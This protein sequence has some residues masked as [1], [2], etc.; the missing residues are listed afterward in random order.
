M[1]AAPAAGLTNLAHLDF[2]SQQVT[3]ADTPAHSSYRLDQDPTV[4][5]L[6]VYAD[7]RSDGTF[8][9]VGGGPLDAVANTYAQGAYDADDIARAA[10]V[11]LRQWRATGDQKAKQQAYQQL[12]GLSYM[13]TLTGPT[14]GEVV[15]WMQPDGSLNP[16]PTPVELPDP[17]DSGASY[18][19]ARS[20]WAFGEGYAAFQ[21][22]DPQF[23]AFLKARMDLAVTA[24]QRDVL[25]GYRSYHIIHGVRVPAWLIVDGADASSEAVLGLAAYMRAGGDRSARTALAQLARGIAAMSDGS[26]T[27]WPYRA[28][29]PWALSRSQWHA[30]GS[31]MPAAL[32]AAATALGDKSL[33]TP[34]ISDAAGFSAQLLTSSGPING[35]QPTPTDATQIAYGADARVQGL[36]A[37]GNAGHRPG[38]RQL[39]GIAAGWFFGQN[40]SGAPVY[41]PATGVTKDGVQADG[42]VN[43]NGGA[44]STI[45]GLLTMQILDAN[46]DLAAVA[47][48]AAAIRTRD[49]LQVVEAETGTLTGPA[50]IVTPDPAWTGESLWS[51]DYVAAGPGS[52]VSWQLPAGDQPRLVQPVV[53]L[54]PGSTA[55]GTFTTGRTTL[56]KVRFG[57]IGAQGTAPSPTELI[58]IELTQTV[59]S[60][61]VSVSVRTAGGTGN[62]DA[63]LIMPE[64]ATLVTDGGG[65][66]LVLLTSKSGTAEHRTIS[67]TGTGRATVTS[68]DRNGRQLNLD[69]T[70]STNISVKVAAGG[71]T[72]AV[73]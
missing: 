73:R 24:L 6:W 49:G 62:I 31:N 26:T 54:T 48:S 55:R 32:A 7:A 59:G 13:Q 21:H 53:E 14:A 34:A 22:T 68:Y 56:G 39:A 41:D 45:H 2:L 19:L 25:G 12:R 9:R 35:L 67:V 51:G 38:I 1:P 46:P 16:S 52:T 70:W 69:R 42:T 40:A 58:P 36:I 43:N 44:E 65:H 27:S 61:A 3:V 20:L 37:V 57:D 63:L 66:S 4:G 28:L 15:L 64:V 11:Y 72:I 8:E 29:L 33:L 47:R 17:S 50:T 23:A 71:F 30:W 60:G 10:V 5:V 18:W